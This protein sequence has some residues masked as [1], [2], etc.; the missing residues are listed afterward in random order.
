[1]GSYQGEV[2]HGMTPLASAGDRRVLNQ[3]DG[4]T[5]FSGAAGTTTLPGSGLWVASEILACRRLRRIAFEASYNAH[6]STTTGFAEIIVMLCRQWTVPLITDDVWT[7]LMVPD[8]SPPA[9]AALASGTLQNTNMSRTVLW[10]K[11]IYRPLVIQ[12]AAAVA[13]S[14]KIR[15]AIDVDVTDASWF[16]LQAREAGDTTNRGILNLAIV[17]GC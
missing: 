13:N 15:G 1:M 8:A 11:V 4:V 9:P 17:G 7:P 14:D 6:A 10:S 16:A 2:D 5:P 3:V 12:I